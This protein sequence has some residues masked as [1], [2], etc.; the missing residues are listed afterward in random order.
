MNERVDVALQGTRSA[1]L[2]ENGDSIA[3]R[4]QREEAE[5]W[6]VLLL[7]A[8]RG[9]Q[10][11]LGPVEVQRSA[12]SAWRGGVGM[13]TPPGARAAKELGAAIQSAVQPSREDATDEPHQLRIQ[14]RLAD[15]GDISLSVERGSEGLKIA[16]GAVEVRTAALL[17]AECHGLAH[18]LASSG[19]RLQSLRVVTMLHSGIDVATRRKSTGKQVPKE[20]A[21]EFVRRTERSK[22]RRLNL[23]G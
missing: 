1:A 6:T 19:L 11:E 3:G 22:S 4:E 7:D 10:H 2:S 9:A 14:L 18:V 12:S 5:K 16:I 23:I 20:V 8:I 13:L 17:E 21:T 15:L